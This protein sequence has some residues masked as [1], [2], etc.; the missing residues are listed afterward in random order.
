MLPQFSVAPPETDQR[1]SDIQE[2]YPKLVSNREEK[3]DDWITDERLEQE[4]RILT[5]NHDIPADE[6]CIPRIGLKEANQRLQ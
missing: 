1:E 4:P 2:Q 6:Q 5:V 3:R